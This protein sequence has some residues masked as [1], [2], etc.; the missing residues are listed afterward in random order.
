[1]SNV[2][3]DRL[4]DL[5][6]HASPRPVPTP[7]DEAAVRAAVQGEWQAVAVKRRTRR[8]IT[9]YA[10]AASVVLAVFATF[11]VF[12]TPSVAPVEVARIAKSFGPVYLLGES[13]ELR[14]TTDLAIVLA[15]QTIV[16]GNDAGL[17]VSW[18]NGG[19]LRVDA[20]TRLS[21]A[22]QDRVHLDSGRVYF[23]SAST[24]VAGISADDPPRLLI[25]TAHGEVRHLGTQYMVSVD[26]ESLV[27]SVREGQV[28]IEGQYHSEVA[29]SGQQVTLSGSAQPS[30]LSISR[31]GGDWEW[32]GRTTPAA[33]VDG[34]TLHEFLVWACREMGLELR[35]EGGAEARARGHDLRG[36][37]DTEPAE[38]VRLRLATMAL[39]WRIEEGVIYISDQ[40]R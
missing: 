40:I 29:N 26:L 24:M 38:A 34:K 15:G 28:D 13:S 11:N 33:E 7:A 20:K 25:E 9:H 36:T 27:V 22:D 31:T 37:I 21:F 30:V 12:R 19:S 14:E 18:G 3:H 8:R 2:D 23:D 16:T 6:R 17:A 4:E 39:D 35:Y 5:L 1:M 10:L 32:I